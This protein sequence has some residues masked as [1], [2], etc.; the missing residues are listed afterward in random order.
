MV[1]SQGPQIPL[2]QENTDGVQP[3]SPNSAA[4]ICLE[5]EGLC[6][7]PVTPSVRVHTVRF[8]V[9]MWWGDL[10]SW[11]CECLANVSV[12]RDILLLCRF[13]QSVALKHRPA[14]AAAA[15]KW[16]PFGFSFSAMP[17]PWDF[18]WHLWLQT[19]LGFCPDLKTYCLHYVAIL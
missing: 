7:L 18:S 16:L 9:I 6:V 10:S 13:P 4:H 12:L 15:E 2:L 17:P 8:T 5:E 19:I 1:C 3:R 14:A 11:D